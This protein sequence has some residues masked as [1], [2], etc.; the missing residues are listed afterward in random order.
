MYYP[1]LE[2]PA[3]VWSQLQPNYQVEA[4][5]YKKS[6]LALSLYWRGTD[7]VNN[8]YDGGNYFNPREEPNYIFEPREVVLSSPFDYG[9]GYLSLANGV[10]LF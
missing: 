3:P 5:T 10:S 9:N 1:A 6:Y 7:G 4:S 8:T 2:T